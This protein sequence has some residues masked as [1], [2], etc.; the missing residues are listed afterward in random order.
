MS[1]RMSG[2]SHC[3]FCSGVPYAARISM[4]PVSGAWL[5]NTTGADR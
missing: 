2:Y 5:P 4:F 3:C 1:C